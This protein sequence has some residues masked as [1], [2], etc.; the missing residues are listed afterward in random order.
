MIEEHLVARNLIRT[1]MEEI[2]NQPYSTLN[3]YPVTVS[4][5]QEYTVLINVTDLSPVEY[6]DSLQKVGVSISRVGKE[7]I[8]VETLKVNR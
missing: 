3:Q 8:T 4:A 1:Q 2:K 5:P 7:I 6:P